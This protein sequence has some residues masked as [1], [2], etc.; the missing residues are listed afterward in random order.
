MAEIAYGIHNLDLSKTT[1]QQKNLLKSKQ[2]EAIARSLGIPVIEVRDRNGRDAMKAMVQLM[3]QETTGR[4]LSG[5][6]TL[7]VAYVPNQPPNSEDVSRIT[8]KIRTA[9]F[10]QL[11]KDATLEVVH[12]D[13]EAISQS[14][15]RGILITE[16]EVGSKEYPLP[17]FQ[18]VHEPSTWTHWWPLIVA[19]ILVCCAGAACAFFAGGDRSR[20]YNGYKDRPDSMQSDDELGGSRSKV[21]PSGSLR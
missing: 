5:I 17:E 1:V 6:E 16:P 7:V 18:E 9:D 21:R 4:R 10:A 11:A 2:A 15:G 3:A 13:S 20:R 12:A 19:V 14:D 8:S